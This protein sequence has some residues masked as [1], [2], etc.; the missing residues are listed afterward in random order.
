MPLCWRRMA[1]PRFATPWL[2]IPKQE[3]LRSTPGEL[4]FGIPEACGRE[5][6]F[7]AHPEPDF[8]IQQSPN[9]VAMVAVAGT[10]LCEQPPDQ[11]RVK[12]ATLYTSRLQQYLLHT[13]HL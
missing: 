4:T 1:H 10:V 13:I 8:Q 7:D 12:Q 6:P 2:I 9:A 5:I 11:P 3:V